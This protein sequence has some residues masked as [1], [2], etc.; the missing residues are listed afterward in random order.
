[1]SKSKANKIISSSEDHILV[2]D[3]KIKKSDIAVFCVCIIIS[4]VIWIYATNVERREAA[5][6]ENIQ[7]EVITSQKA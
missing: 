6:L 5:K 7:N 3:K 4:L 1:M 2:R